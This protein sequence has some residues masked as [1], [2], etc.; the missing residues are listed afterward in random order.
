MSGLLCTT[1]CEFPVI[2][3]ALKIEGKTSSYKIDSKQSQV[4]CP[5][6]GSSLYRMGS[7]VSKINVYTGVLEIESGQV[8]VKGQCC[9]EEAIDGGLASW[10]DL[11]HEYSGQCMQHSKTAVAHRS[12]GSM[13]LEQPLDIRASCH[14]G[15]VRFAISPA[16]QVSTQLSSPYPDLIVPFQ[17]GPS[18][19]EKNSKWWL[20]ANGTRYFAGTC[21]CRSCRLASGNDIQTW[22]FIPKDNMRQ[23]NGDPLEYDMGTLNQYGSSKGVYRNFCSMCGATV[24]W[25]NDE[26]PYLIDVS[27]GLLEAESGARAEELLEWATARVSFQEEAQNKAL[28]EMLREG[29]AKQAQ[30]EL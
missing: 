18:K 13:N 30:K 10:L 27:A 26:R 24:F 7:D 28:I 21:A 16:S 19:N 2:P 8:E 1:V 14:C 9:M 17:S 29:L 25:H 22:A 6:C 15:G 12:S 5:G 23:M 11:H 20:R 3:S 4:F